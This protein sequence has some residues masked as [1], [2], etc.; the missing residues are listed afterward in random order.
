MH[1]TSEQPTAIIYIYVR[2]EV[3]TAMFIQTSSSLLHVVVEEHTTTNVKDV[4][5]DEGGSR[6]L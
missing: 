3:F 1:S 4:S 2:P 6:C 5:P